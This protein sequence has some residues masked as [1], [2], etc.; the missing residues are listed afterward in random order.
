MATTPMAAAEAICLTLK[1]FEAKLQAVLNVLEEQSKWRKPRA[2]AKLVQQKGIFRSVLDWPLNRQLKGRLAI[3]LQDSLEGL[4]EV[5]AFRA[6]WGCLFC[7]MAILGAGFGFRHM[8]EARTSR[9]YQEQSTQFQNWR[10]QQS[11]QFDAQRLQGMRDAE[12]FR[13]KVTA[14]AEQ[15]CREEV[16]A[17]LQKLEPASYRLAQQFERSSRLISLADG[18]RAREVK[19][20]EADG[21]IES[22]MDIDTLPY[23]PGILLYL[24]DAPDRLPLPTTAPAPT[25]VADTKK[26]EANAV[27]AKQF[28]DL[29]QWAVSCRGH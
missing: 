5:V 14:E 8:Y 3:F 6:R 25:P 21:F 23:R 19:L 18:T 15:R 12:A 1:P 4:E 24:T 2:T 16:S 17:Q 9:W 26:S 20:G 28:N 13:S 7:M 11:E 22:R 29:S 10:L 27:E